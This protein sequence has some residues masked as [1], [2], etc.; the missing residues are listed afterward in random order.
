MKVSENLVYYKHQAQ[1]IGFV[2]LGKVD[3]E[4]AQEVIRIA[5]KM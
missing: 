2:Q 1:V 3:D 5:V 4:L